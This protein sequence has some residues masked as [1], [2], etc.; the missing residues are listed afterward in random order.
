MNNSIRFTHIL[1]VVALFTAPIQAFSNEFKELLNSKELKRLESAEKLIAKGDVFIEETKDLE[2]EVE[3]LKNADGRIKTGKIN[4]YNKKIAQ[5]KAKAALYYEDGY[6]KYISVLDDRLKTLEKS[7]NSE[8]K[9]TRRDSR[10]L[11][12]KARKQYNKAENLS[13][14]EKAVELLEL[15][16][17]NQQ[18]AIE[19]Q[20]KCLLSLSE[21]IETEPEL[22][23]EEVTAIDSTLIE[24]ALVEVAPIAQDTT[25]VMTELPAETP[26]V[27]APVILAVA[28]VTMT[29]MPIP[30]DSTL[31]AQNETPL[32]EEV[33]APTVIEPEVPIAVEEPIVVNPDIFL[34]IQIMADKKKATN[35][36]ISSVYKGSKEVI[37][38][39]INDW[40][41]Y[42]V[43]KYQSLEKAKADMKTEN[44]K[45]FIVAYNKNERISVKEAVTLLNG[46]S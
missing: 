2:K 33:A 15:A 17:Q 42:S 10:D 45:G 20:T 18:E 24:P 43:G 46:E 21:P 3:Q 9:Q 41:K 14:P 16:Q 31:T 36:Q 27:K 23:A 40:F 25:T 34:T 7:G 13:S 4:K 29:A 44:I 37:E 28:P 32:I 11:E 22:M 38:M 35:E 26:V 19:L 39:S 12:K 6:K 30:A 1:L 8:A 5:I